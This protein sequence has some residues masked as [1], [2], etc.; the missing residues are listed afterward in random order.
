[1]PT[2]RVSLRRAQG[3]PNLLAIQHALVFDEPP[4]EPSDLVERAQIWA[5]SRDAA[6]WRGVLPG[7]ELWAQHRDEVLAYWV[8]AHPGTRPLGW[9]RL[10]APGLRQRIGGVGEPWQTRDV[11]YGVPLVWNAGRYLNLWPNPPMPIDGANPPTFESSATYLDRHALLGLG[12]R[13]RLADDDFRPQS[14]FDILD[15]G[16]AGA[17]SPPRL[18]GGLPRPNRPP[19]GEATSVAQPF[20]ALR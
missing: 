5:W 10:E 17:P 4:P 2:N 1:V 13:D 15:F 16:E 6:A 14:I 11:L 18:F 8:E 20:A 7:A 19:H 12:E 3:R 9:W